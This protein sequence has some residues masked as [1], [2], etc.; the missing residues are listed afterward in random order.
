MESNDITSLASIDSALLASNKYDETYTDSKQAIK[1]IGFFGTFMN[2]LNLMHG[3][4]MLTISNSFTFCGLVPST[5]VFLFAALVCYGIGVMT[6]KLSFNLET[7]S[8]GEMVSKYLG[9]YGA[10]LYHFSM[11]L[12]CL[13]CMISYVII[14]GT[15]VCEW[16]GWTGIDIKPDNENKWYYK[17]VVLGFSIL[18]VSFTIPKKMGCL[19]GFS[20]FSVV[21]LFVYV[22]AI[23]YRGIAKLPFDG[24]N[25]TVKTSD[26]RIEALN[27]FSLYLLSFSLAAFILPVLA[28][29][30][31][32]YKRRLGLMSLSYL[33]C[34]L[35]VGS[36]GL[37]G[38]L[39][40]GAD[41][42]PNILNSF[43]SSD[44]L[45]VIVRICYFFVI[46]AT[47]PVIALSIM[48]TLSRVFYNIDNPVDLPNKSRA[49]VLVIV[50]LP[51]VLLGMFMP[52]IRPAMAIGGAFAGCV[53][54]FILPPL[55]WIRSS[56][57]KLSHWSNV[58]CILIIVFGVVSTVTCTYESIVD[59]IR[60]FKKSGIF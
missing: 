36:T 6:I 27:S 17:L 12:F 3:S 50:N 24:I 23:I 2:L 48:Q 13:S 49:I 20:F 22:I 38:Y 10:G 5:M 31:P 44:I 19:S 53:T 43:P 47:Y 30:H 4:G 42:A 40:F 25:P 54:N 52:N 26:F 16:I 35:F 15:T 21:C 56:K 57:E 55:V 45:M 11:I 8:L 59:A 39:L 14:G 32:V 46:T 9:K 41:A 51:T 60:E 1:Y 28:T 18:P 33:C 37:I 58:G 7:D 29:T 34:I